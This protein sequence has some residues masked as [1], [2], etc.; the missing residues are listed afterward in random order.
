MNTPKVFGFLAAVLIT[1]AQIAV[2]AANT[3]AFA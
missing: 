3:A 2:F 1:V